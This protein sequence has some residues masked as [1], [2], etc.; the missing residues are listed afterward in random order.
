VSKPSHLRG[1]NECAPIV[2]PTMALDRCHPFKLEWRPTSS[3]DSRYAAHIGREKYI[4]NAASFID[5]A[6]V[7]RAGNR[8]EDSIH[9]AHRV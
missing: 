5:F 7:S 2:R 1:I 3:E 6:R 8:A 9:S 4:I